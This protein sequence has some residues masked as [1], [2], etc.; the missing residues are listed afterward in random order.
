MTPEQ[1]TMVQQSFQQVL[2]IRVQA[3]QIFYDRLFALDPSLRPL[4]KGDMRAQGAKLMAA[5][6]MVVGGL[7]RLDELLGEVQ[8]LARRHV[9]YGV[10]ERHYAV[11]GSALLGTLEQAFGAAF[12]PALSAAWGAAYQTLASAMIAAARDLP[13]AA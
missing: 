5:L 7:E 8:A 3:A 1:I 12:T 4:F 9:G 2:P 6:A 11:V 13:Q 10:Q